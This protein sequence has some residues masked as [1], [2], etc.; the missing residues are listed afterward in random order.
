MAI[1]VKTS[2][3]PLDNNLKYLLQRVNIPHVFQI[4]LKGKDD[5]MH[6]KIGHSNIRIMPAW[7]FLGNL[8]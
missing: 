4:H 6:E 1:E 5:W 2:Q 7:R 3:Q 8:V